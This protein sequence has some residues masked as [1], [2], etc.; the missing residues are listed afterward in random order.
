MNIVGRPL[1]GDDGVTY[2]NQCALEREECRTKRKINVD[3]NGECC[4]S[5]QF[6]CNDGTCISLREDV[7]TNLPDSIFKFKT[8]CF[9]IFP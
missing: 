8:L 3:H 2:S 9:Y 5:S 1:C 6:R 7:L 4:L